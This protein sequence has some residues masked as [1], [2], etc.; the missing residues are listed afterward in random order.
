MLGLLLNNWTC[1]K[2]NGWSKEHPERAWKDPWKG[3][4]QARYQDVQGVILWSIYDKHGHAIFSDPV[5]GIRATCRQLYKYQLAGHCTL[6]QIVSQW[7]PSEDGNDVDNYVRTLTQI[8]RGLSSIGVTG[9]L[10]RDDGKVNRMDLLSTLIA[11]MCR[12]E[13]WAGFQAP[14]QTIHNGIQLYIHDFCK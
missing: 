13:L 7:A 1:I 9:N 8:D 6:R 12:M 11:A 10:F 4:G 3:S 14:A 2:Q 5:W